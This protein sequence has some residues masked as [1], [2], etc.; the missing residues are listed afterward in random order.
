MLPKRHN[1]TSQRI[2]YRW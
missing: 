2:S 1:E